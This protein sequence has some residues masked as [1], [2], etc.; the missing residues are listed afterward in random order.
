MFANLRFLR[1]ANS[2]R[3]E[4]C[5]WYRKLPT[6]QDMGNSELLR[7]ISGVLTQTLCTV[8]PA[9]PLDLRYDIATRT[10]PDLSPAW[11]NASREVPV[12]TIS[13][14]ARESQERRSSDSGHGAGTSRR[15]ATQRHDAFHLEYRWAW[16]DSVIPGRAYP[17]GPSR[18]GLV[19]FRMAAST[20]CFP[21]RQR[22][23]QQAMRRG[24]GTL[25]P[26]MEALSGFPSVQDD[27]ISKG[28]QSPLARMELDACRP[29]QPPRG[30]QPDCC[31]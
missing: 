25:S 29:N 23:V 9:I 15:T 24:P 2:P 1:L 5:I 18:S 8:L 10:F 28:F 21:N 26:R 16:A 14:P 20:E 22:C 7:Q 3:S 30:I 6:A 4:S 19:A 17:S 27:C 12:S 13:T 11:L 31:R